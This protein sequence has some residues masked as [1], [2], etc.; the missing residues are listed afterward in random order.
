MH[1]MEKATSF[2]ISLV[3]GALAVA[4]FKRVWQVAAGEGEAPEPNDLERA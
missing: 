4:L 3:S 1:P 2:G